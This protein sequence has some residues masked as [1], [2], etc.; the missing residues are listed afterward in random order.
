M[1]FSQLNWFENV[2]P[3]PH[4]WPGLN[5]LSPMLYVTDIQAAVNFYEKAFGF[6]P[7]FQLPDANGIFIF[8][9]MRY[10]GINFTLN[11][12][13]C[14][15]FDGKCP[16]SSQTV[17]P[18]MF[19]FYVDDIDQAMQQALAS[20]AELLQAIRLE[21]WGDRKGR[22]RDPFGYIWEMAARVQ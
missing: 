15:D 21:F 22:V 5:W 10:R 18:L 17:P 16:Q 2:D 6:V 19:Y 3:R 11:Q 13:G 8:A 4:P 14:F 9:R 12:E 7:I 1:S 20:G